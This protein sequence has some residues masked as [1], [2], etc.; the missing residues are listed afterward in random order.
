MAGS[1][2]SSPPD[3]PD[4]SQV[5]GVFLAQQVVAVVSLAAFVLIVAFA[6]RGAQRRQPVAGAV[7]ARPH[8]TNPGL[9]VGAD[10][11]V[12]TSKTI[13]V[14]WTVTLRLLPSHA[15]PGVGRPAVS[16]GAAAVRA[17]T[18]WIRRRRPCPASLIVSNP[19]RGPYAA[20]IAAKGIVTSRIA[21]GGLQKSTSR[22]SAR[23]SDVVTD[24]SG[25]V[26][27]VDFQYTLFNLIAIVFVLTQ[28]VP[29]PA[30]GIPALPAAFAVL[31]GVSAGVYTANKAVGNNSPSISLVAPAVARPGQTIQ[32]RGANLVVNGESNAALG[33]GMDTSIHLTPCIP[34]GPGTPE[35]EAIILLP[36]KAPTET[37]LECTVPMETLPS[38][39]D[40]TVVTNANG[41]ASQP[42]ALQILP[43][44]AS[45]GQAHACRPPTQPAAANTL[46]DAPLGADLSD[47]Q[48]LPGGTGV[49]G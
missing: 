25:A 27:L 34:S 13:A 12:S 15:G 2:A 48:V 3:L 5:S 40:V 32:I 43:P 45:S 35:A 7:G 37:L 47:G 49:G 1:S 19:A 36:Q 46:A 18:N 26:D 39:Y 24:D 22:T 17:D 30:H 14:L 6:A 8:R 20:A 9:F 11:R 21:G 31:T 44:M 42:G 10:N 33:S 28:F 23:V 4:L 16:S 41:L 38:S 29:H